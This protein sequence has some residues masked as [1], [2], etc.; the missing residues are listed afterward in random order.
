MAGI[1]QEVE[2]GI[3]EAK[4]ITETVA[5]IAPGVEDVIRR[6]VA[7]RANPTSLFAEIEPIIS[8]LEAIRLK[9]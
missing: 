6:L 7:I 8:D 5:A 3:A 1:V 9:L 2:T 4:T